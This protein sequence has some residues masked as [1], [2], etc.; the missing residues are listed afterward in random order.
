MEMRLWHAWFIKNNT[1]LRLL[2]SLSNNG[3][4]PPDSP[5]WNPRRP[6]KLLETHC[7]PSQLS[8][9][10]K[11]GALSAFYF[12]GGMKSFCSKRI[13]DVIRLYLCRLETHVKSKIKYTN[14]YIASFGKIMP[15]CRTRHCFTPRFPTPR[16]KHTSRWHKHNNANTMH[17]AGTSVVG[18]QIYGHEIGSESA[19]SWK[20][21]SLRLS[22][23]K[24]SEY[25]WLVLL[26]RHITEWFS[27]L[28][29]PCVLS[30]HVN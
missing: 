2:F 14:T 6:T 28:S 3:W 25:F 8:S 10:R 16:S 19:K 29:F 7:S 15:N 23:P 18:G 22:S 30:F 26:K 21:F 13:A 24:D 20:D 4:I 12:R 5:P 11:N 1:R 27:K 17:N 9:Q